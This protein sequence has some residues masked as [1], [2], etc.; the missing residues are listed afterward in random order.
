MAGGEIRANARIE[1][2]EHVIHS[3]LGAELIDAR[4]CGAAMATAAMQQVCTRP[5]TVRKCRHPDFGQERW[6]RSETLQGSTGWRGGGYN[7]DAYCS[8]YISSIVTSRQLGGK[9]YNID[10]VGKREEGKWTGTF[11]RKRKYN[12]HC[13]VSLQW[14]PI[15]NERT[16]ERCNPL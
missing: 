14:D 8:D 9:A 2:Y 1:T 7:P 10:I 11:G 3:Q 4:K 5:I 13:T 6:A 15:Y 12:Y 16:D